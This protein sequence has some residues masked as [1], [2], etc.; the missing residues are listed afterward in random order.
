MYPMDPLCLCLAGW[1]QA[2]IKVPYL[3]YPFS[4]SFSLRLILLALIKSLAHLE[5]H[6]P[7]L[8]DLA[9]DESG[10]PGEDAVLHGRGE[11]ASLGGIGGQVPAHDVLN[12]L[13]GQDEQNCGEE[14]LVSERGN[15]INNLIQTRVDWSV[16]TKVETQVK[17]LI[18]FL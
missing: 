1:F 16:K 6:V 13:R 5:P 7:E 4:A 15:L 9:P 2:Y 14:S 12:P 3:P 11:G 18:I 8:L 17:K 10:H